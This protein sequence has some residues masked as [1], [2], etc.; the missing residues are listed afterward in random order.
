MADSAAV[1]LFTE[2]AGYVERAVRPYAEKLAELEARHAIELADLK[3]QIAARP[4]AIAQAEM[5]VRAVA[6]ALSTVPRPLNGL[7]GRDGVDGRDGADAEIDYERVGGMLK[8]FV[9]AIPPA[10]PGRDGADAAVDYDRI[11]EVIAVAVEK[12]VAK[13]PVPRDGR[14]GAPGRHGDDGRNGADGKDAPAVDLEALAVRVLGLVPAPRD[15]KDGRDGERGERGEA[16]AKG[17]DADANAIVERVVALIPKPRDGVD[18]KAGRDGVDGDDGRNGADGAPGRD[19]VDGKPGSNGVDG[20]AGAD[21]IDGA[22]GRDGRDGSDGERGPP[23]ERGVDGADG[24]TP[25]DL[26]LAYNE[27]AGELVVR[28]QA[29]LR[30]IERTL[31]LAVPLDAGVYQRG[32]TYRKGSIVTFAGS[33]FIARRDTS[34]LIGGDP[35]SPDW[36]LMVKRGQDGRT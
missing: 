36:R 33:A 13:F 20:K 21:G 23:G 30:V 32:K 3:A 17:A 10:A 34:E 27:E 35:P 19:G 6:D 24:F 2:V 29:G 8:A 25:N 28:M 16:G 31:R 15:G 22:P 14:D 12:Q 1:E 5:I 18:G 4:D 7:P 26:E 9:D 11:G